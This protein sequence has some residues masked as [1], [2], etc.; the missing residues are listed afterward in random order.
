MPDSAVVTA[1]KPVW[2]D[3]SSKD[4]K[5]TQKFYADLFG[6]DI[7][8]L[9]PDAGG[10][11]FFMKNGKMVA[12]SGPI[13]MDQQP[14]VW[15]IFIGTGDID[16]TADKVKKAGGTVIV[17]PMDVM[18]V[19]KMAVFQDPTG[20]YIS[21]W[22]AIT[23]GTM[24]VEGEPNTFGW[25]EITCRGIDKAK[26]FYNSV[27]GW[28]VKE[29]PAGEFTYNEWQLDGQSICGGM[30]MPSNVPAQVPSYWMPYFSVEN[31]EDAWKKAQGLGA[32][33]MVEPTE[34]PGGRFA[35]LSDPQ[36]ASFGLLVDRS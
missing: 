3:I 21:S 22:Q 10:Y 7:Q 5:G 24:E 32:K 34:Y 6:W 29:S 35:I 30:E 26:A 11:V 1:A 18:G 23:G 20:A 12:G 27:F 31:L 15:S 33:P 28:G 4:P 19:G 16:A 25:A 13:Q 14:T 8:D 2:V 9:G 36:G 17:E